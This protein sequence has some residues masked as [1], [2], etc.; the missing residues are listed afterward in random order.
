MQNEGGIGNT[1]GSY[2]CAQN[3][4][5]TVITLPGP[6]GSAWNKLR[7]DGFKEAMGKCPDAKLVGNTFGGNIAIEEGQRQAADQLL[8]APQAD[9]IYAVAGIF[10]V[11]VAQQVRRMNSKAKVVTRPA[12]GAAL[13]PR[14]TPRGSW[15]A[16]RTN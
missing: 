11:G 14:P 16:T 1:L 5:A 9:Y 10:S 13:G 4:K 12:L 7:F 3:P 8:K 6:A 2:I 15:S